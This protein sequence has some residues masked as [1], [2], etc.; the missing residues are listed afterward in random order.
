MK[1]AGIET[2]AGQKLEHVQ[3]VLGKGMVPERAE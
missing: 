2:V 1:D 3:I